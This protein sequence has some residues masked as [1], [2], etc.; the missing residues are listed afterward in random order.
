MYWLFNSD[1]NGVESKF[2][3]CQ[4]FM[5]PFYGTFVVHGLPIVWKKVS[6]RFLNTFLLDPVLL[7]LF[8]QGSTVAVLCL[9]KIWTKVKWWYQYHV[10]KHTH[11]HTHLVRSQHRVTDVLHASLELL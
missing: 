5:G 7:L 2:V 9:N 4:I 3:F 10:R 1:L 8:K 6:M 11:T